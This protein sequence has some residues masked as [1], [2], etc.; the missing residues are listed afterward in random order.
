MTSDTNPEESSVERAERLGGYGSPTP[1][2]EMGPGA[3]QQDAGQAS[4]EEGDKEESG[5]S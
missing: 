4:E 3:E 5:D 1:E 2:Q